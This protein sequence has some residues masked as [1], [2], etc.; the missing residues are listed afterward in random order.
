[1]VTINKQKI[2]MYIY[3]KITLDIGAFVSTGKIPRS[4]ILFINFYKNV[5][6]YTPTSRV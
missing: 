1:M 6:I 2:I 3:P 5:P 4:K